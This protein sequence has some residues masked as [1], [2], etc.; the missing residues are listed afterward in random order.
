MYSRPKGELALVAAIATA[1]ADTLQTEIG[2]LLGRQ[3]FL[4]TTFEPVPAG[5]PGAVS[6]EGTLAGLAASAFLSGVAILAGLIPWAAFPVV[7]IAAF[8]GT[9]LESY[10]GA[11]PRRREWLGGAGLNFTATLTGALA[12]MILAGLFPD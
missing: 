6:L 7:L 2:M 8:A 9:F 3:P 4:P 1:L 10:L 5:T 11:C 12:A